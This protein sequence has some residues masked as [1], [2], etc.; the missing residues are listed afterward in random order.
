MVASR[1]GGWWHYAAGAVQFVADL[2]SGL[3]KPWGLPPAEPTVQAV[4]AN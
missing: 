4:A 2:I 3:L 1:N